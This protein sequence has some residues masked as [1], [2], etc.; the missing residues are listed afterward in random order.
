[1]PEIQ[2]NEYH[3]VPILEAFAYKRTPNDVPSIFLMNGRQRFHRQT[4]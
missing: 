2:T 1:M 3:H 4:V